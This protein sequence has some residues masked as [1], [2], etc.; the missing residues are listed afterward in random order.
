M[1]TK[2]KT[3]EGCGCA[4]ACGGEAP[5]GDA[6]LPDDIVQEIARCR[7][8]A[9]SESYLI[10]ILQKVQT[11][12]GYLSRKH[13]DQVSELLQV[14]AAKVTGVASFYH[15]FSFSP[16]GK[17]RVSVCLGTA[18]YVK[19]SGKLMERFKEL[20]GVPEGK[21]TKDGLFSLE[22]SRCFG[23]CALAPV[24][25]VNDKV[26]GE[27]KPDDALKILTEYGFKPRTDG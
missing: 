9:H 11:R 15:F 12:I 1:T 23:A 3:A 20:L 18:C 17:F 19:G 16:R 8:Q 6:P 27:V 14:P 26:Y 22:A 10:A 24:V 5:K 21:T 13:M 2:K 7:K 25:V 4:C